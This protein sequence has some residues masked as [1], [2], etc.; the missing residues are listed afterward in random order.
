MASELPFRRIVGV[1]FDGELHR[2]AEE[3]IRKYQSPTQ[4]CSNFELLHLDATNY[5]IPNEKTIYYIYNSFQEEVLAKVLAN[6]KQSLAQ[7]QREVFIVYCN[8]VHR[9]LVSRCGFTTVETTK[10]HA[11]YRSER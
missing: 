6:I 9:D 4:K 5:S 11:I 2:V 8:A 1:E 10:W 7:N 3:N